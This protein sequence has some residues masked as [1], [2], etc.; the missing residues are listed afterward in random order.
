MP[1]AEPTTVPTR[2]P[3]TKPTV[4]PSRH[5]S[6]S[7]TEAASLSPTQSPTRFPTF[8]P[9]FSPTKFGTHHPTHSPTRH[10]SK[11]PTGFP[12]VTPTFSP[13]FR[14]TD[15]AHPT[16]APTPPTEAPT[17]GAI[18]VPSESAAAALDAKYLETNR[19]YEQLE[20]K[21]IVHFQSLLAF[22]FGLGFVSFLCVRFKLLN[23]I[24]R[25]G[26]TQ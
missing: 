8:V 7:P 15:T 23:K 4:Q 16:F 26:L 22:A 5:P 2:H 21:S 1:T 6:H 9:T 17:V 18:S 19:H 25:I 13:T 20:T 14:H 24:T 3:S 11:T 12:T 10:Q